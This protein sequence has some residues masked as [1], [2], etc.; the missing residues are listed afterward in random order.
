LLTL[1]GCGDK[2]EELSE[3]ERPTVAFEGQVDPAYVGVWKASDGNS[4]YT[5]GKSGDMTIKGK[6]STPKGM[7]DYTIQGAWRMKD[8]LF[9]SKDP[10]GNVTPYKAT[11]KGDRLTLALTGRM[12]SETVLVRQ[13]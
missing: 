8:G 3:P 2:D 1:S 4:A 9:I 12:K 5:L 13:P 11:L 7:K 10:Q 6:A